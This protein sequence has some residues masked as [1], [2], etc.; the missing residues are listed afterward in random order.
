MRTCQ[1]FGMEG[2]ARLGS[3]LDR[4]PWIFVQ[5]K[6][7]RM[8]VSMYAIWLWLGDG[9]VFRVQSEMHDLDG[10]DPVGS[11]Q[12]GQVAPPGAVSTLIEFGS[13][14]QGIASVE[15]LIIDEPGYS[16]L[17]LFEDH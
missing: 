2:P 9:G 4:A 11:Q 8:H 15:T 17:S 3:A 1:I 12:I 7:L 13:Q 5:D 6:V 16:A 10:W 14:W